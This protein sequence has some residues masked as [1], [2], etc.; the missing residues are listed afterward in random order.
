M[1]QNEFPSSGVWYA[2]IKGAYLKGADLLG[3]DLFDA[4]GKYII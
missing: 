2:I 4:Y 1:P 3:A